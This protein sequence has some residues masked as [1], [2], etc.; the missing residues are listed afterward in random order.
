MT[1]SNSFQFPEINREI[2][3][4]AFYENLENVPAL[5]ETEEIPVEDKIVKAHYFA[6]SCDFYVVE[7]NPEDGEAFG[8]TKF[9]AFESGEWGYIDLPT[10]E[11]NKT[12]A[13]GLGLVIERDLYWSEEKFSEVLKQR[14]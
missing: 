13:S 10:M 12:L 6:Q 11:S 2:R 4:H 1:T 3:G 7:I 14:G 9:A 8:Y 5:Y